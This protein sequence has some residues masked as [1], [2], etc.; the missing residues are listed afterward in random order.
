MARIG[1]IGCGTMGEAILAGLLS[2]EGGPTVQVVTTRRSEAAGRLV[3]RYGVTALTEN[4]PAVEWSD[5]ILLCVKPQAVYQVVSEP[6]FKRAIKGKLLIS[7][8]AGV[9]SQRLATLLPDTAIVR[10][11]PNTPCLIQ[12]GMTVICPGP[13]AR[14]EH[15]ELA[16]DIFGAVGRVTVLEEKHTALRTLQC[17]H[18]AI[19]THMGRTAASFVGACVEAALSWKSVGVDVDVDDDDNDNDKSLFLFANLL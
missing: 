17:F 13:H 19:G 3:E 11:M 12:E 4:Q 1:I 10:A 2:V 7:I 5:V 15:L 14:A 6:G 16:V 18:C 9:T 8:S